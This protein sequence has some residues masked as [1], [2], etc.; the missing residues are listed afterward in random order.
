MQSGVVSPHLCAVCMIFIF[1]CDAYL[2]CSP[3]CSCG[4][5]TTL[6]K[7]LSSLDHSCL[8]SFPL[9]CCKQ[10]FAHLPLPFSC[11]DCPVSMQTWLF[12]HS[13]ELLFRLKFFGFLVALISFHLQPG[14][15]TLK[16][17]V[18]PIFLEKQLKFTQPVKSPGFLFTF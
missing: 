8:S 17:A 10:R 16:R 14:P 1:I 3:E 13:C 18:I 2:H 5:L 4:G 15:K 12:A 11:P 7:A 6:M 9:I